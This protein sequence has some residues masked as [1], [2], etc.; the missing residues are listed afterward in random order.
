MTEKETSTAPAGESPS[1]GDQLEKRVAYLERKVKGMTEN[2]K[3]FVGK[4]VEEGT[5][6]T[7]G[8]I[9]MA[10]LPVLLAV[11]L[12]AGAACAETIVAHTDDDGSQTEVYT[13]A[14]DSDG[15]ATETLTGSLTVSETVSAEQITTT[16]DMTVADDLAVT[17]LATVGETLGVTG[18]VTL[19]AAPKFTATTASGSATAL[20]TNAPAITEET[21]TWL[22]VTIG[23]DNYVI[24]AWDL[25]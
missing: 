16:D 1:S 2:W 21:P 20:M 5:D 24:P 14:G 9:R 19:T 17:G 11:G 25:D 7:V 23:A 12:I 8:A 18:V 22:T 10:L 13:L 3:R 4:C 15:T 6:G